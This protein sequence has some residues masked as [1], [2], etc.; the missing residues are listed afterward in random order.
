MSAKDIIKKSVLEG[1]SMEM[2][3]YHII[4]ILLV[5]VVLSMYIFYIY[6]LNSHS[7][8]YSRD[9]NKTL[10]IMP[11]LTA[12]IVLALQSSIVISLGMVG[13][14]SIVRFRNAIKSPMDLLFLF[15]SISTGII[16][17]AGLYVLAIVT[18]LIV[19]ILSFLL[20]FIKMP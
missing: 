13:A 4:F 10:A 3:V 7:S 15:W 1:F 20:D 18:C 9:F 14:L 16:C 19:T 6:R 12:A 8:F 11:V 5:T 2:S 17:G